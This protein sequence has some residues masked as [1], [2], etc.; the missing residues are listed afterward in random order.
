MFEAPA[1]DLA[2]RMEFG[3]ARSALDVGTGTGIVAL[4]AACPVVVGVDP[5]VELLRRARR[6][7][8]RLVAVA[9]AQGL[10]FA[11]TTFDR[12]T[13]GFVL[14]HVPSYADALRDMARVTR[15]GGRLGLTAWASRDTEYRDCWERLMGR[16]V[17]VRAVEADALPWEE[18]LAE[19]GN[20]G[21]ALSEAGLRGV[22]VE[23]RAYPIE[24]TVESFLAMRETSTAARYLRRSD[25]TAWE[26]FRGMAAEEFQ[27]RFRDPVVFTHR[28]WIA[29][30]SR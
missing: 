28:A 1:R 30:G 22:A 5:S 3:S 4:Q 6:N 13:A 25:P 24:M 15:R 14:S 18:W 16:F 26:R 12:V 17:D 7:G 29:T 8:V 2:A 21:A 10:P 27:R 11:D 19:P 9:G 20:V 23:E